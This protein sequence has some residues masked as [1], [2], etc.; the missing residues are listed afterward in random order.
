M[1]FTMKGPKMYPNYKSGTPYKSPLHE[2]EETK[3]KKTETKKTETNK[4][5][6]IT[7]GEEK[8]TSNT[9]T[10]NNRGGTNNKKTYETKGTSSTYTPPKK[11]K[12]GDEKY[13]NMTPAERKAADNKYK[14]ANTKTKVHVKNREENSSTSGSYPKIPMKPAKL[15]PT[16]EMKPVEPGK[17]PDPKKPPPPPP[18]RKKRRK[19]KKVNWRQTGLKI[20]NA[21]RKVNPIRGIKKM[22]KGE[23]CYS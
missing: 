15:L 21:V 23:T 11:T 5:D 6:N 10:K 12:E 3:T 16:T 9:T 2:G 8:E 18:P 20:R 19:R 1:A 17:M 14:K 7:W 4:T 13:A 22:C